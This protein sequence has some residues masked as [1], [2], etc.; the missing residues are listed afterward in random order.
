MSRKNSMPMWLPFG[1]AASFLVM[2]AAG[3]RAGWKTDT[4]KPRFQ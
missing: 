3:A 4:P 1:L 2:L